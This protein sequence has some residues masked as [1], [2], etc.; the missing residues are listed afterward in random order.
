MISSRLPITAEPDPNFLRMGDAISKEA[1]D[2][3]AKMPNQGVCAYCG[4]MAQAWDHVFPHCADA[5]GYKRQWNRGVLPCCH[6]C[7]SRLSSSIFETLTDRLAH[8]AGLVRRKYKKLLSGPEWTDEDIEEMGPGLR[9]AMRTA[10][11]QR[12]LVEARLWFLE[13]GDFKVFFDMPP[14]GIA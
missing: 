6:D 7:N 3:L 14:E 4:D 1:D 10:R 5:A 8:L 2:F 9:S 12:K 13:R 11:L